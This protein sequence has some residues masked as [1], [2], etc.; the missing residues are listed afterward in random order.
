M[1]T[2]GLTIYNYTINVSD[3]VGDSSIVFFIICCCCR[4][5]NFPSDLPQTCVLRPQSFV[6][7]F[8]LC[9]YVSVSMNKG[10]QTHRKQGDKT[11]KVYRFTFCI[12]EGI[13]INE[14]YFQ[15]IRV[16]SFP[17]L[18]LLPMLMNQVDTRRI[19]CVRHPSFFICRTYVF[20]LF[21]YD[22]PKFV[23]SFFRPHRYNYSLPFL[24]FFFV[25][26][27]CFFQNL[28]FSR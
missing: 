5:P 16:V 10:C 27:S 18:I 13:V 17:S 28:L 25:Y 11:L 12:Q 1:I 15:L 24:K 3:P 19:F 14:I 26:D 20:S 7:L 2:L 9:L 22:E 23:I 4:F 21:L 8:S 6:S